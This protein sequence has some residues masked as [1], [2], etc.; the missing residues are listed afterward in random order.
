[1]LAARCPERDSW[2]GSEQATVRRRREDFVEI[3]DE[4]RNYEVEIVNKMAISSQAV[5]LLPSDVSGGLPKYPA[6]NLPATL[7]RVRR[8]KIEL[9]FK[10]QKEITS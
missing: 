4:E 1:M 5:C 9:L 3:G 8:R 6:I 7:L 2:R 10:S